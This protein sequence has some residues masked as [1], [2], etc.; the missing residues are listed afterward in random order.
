MLKQRSACL[1]SSPYG[2]SGE[3]YD[4]WRVVTVTTQCTERE[5]DVGG[6]DRHELLARTAFDR[7]IAPPPRLIDLPFTIIDNGGIV[8]LL[9]V[10]AEHPVLSE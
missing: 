8:G 2:T 3:V 9:P 5:G 10:I 6:R 1:V 4:G 7:R